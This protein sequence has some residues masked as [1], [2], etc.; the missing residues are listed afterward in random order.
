MNEQL[1]E[2]AKQVIPEWYSDKEIKKYEDK[3]GE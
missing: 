1:A 3:H 2:L